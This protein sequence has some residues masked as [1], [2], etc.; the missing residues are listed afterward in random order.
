MVQ[1]LF[2]S[3]LALVAA[4]WFSTPAMA[5]RPHAWGL[6]FQEPASPVMERVTSLHDLL[7]WVI[8]FICLFVL[9]L[10]LVACWRFREGANRA[11]SKRSHNTLLEISW[12]AVP[13]LILVVVAIPSFKLLYFQEVLPETEMT[14]KVTGF[15]W[16][17]GYQY[18]DQEGFEFVANMVAEEDLQDG[19][20]RLLQTDNVVVVPTETNIRVQITASD[21]LHSWA[22]PAFGIKIDAVPGRLNEGWFRVD[23]PGTYYGQ[24]SELCGTNHAF[25]PITL[26]AVPRAEFDTWVEQAKAEF[27]R[28]DGAP[29]RVA[30]PAP[31][32]AT[33][34]AAPQLAGTPTELAARLAPGIP[35]E[36]AA[37]MAPGLA[38]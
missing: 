26:Q 14:V 18:P 12:T 33:V 13:V 17:W 38:R 21:V 31:V 11:P 1:R 29:I 6:G 2:A 7:L 3:M 10:L 23:R 24:C 25:M 5:D 8:A 20:P 16:Y 4:A 28:A 15:Q 30:A 37:G 19:Q 36:P 22:M 9:A 32:E 35:T 27:A 34:S